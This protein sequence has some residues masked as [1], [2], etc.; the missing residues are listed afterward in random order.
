MKI[1]LVS[2]YDFSSPGGV[3]THINA[4]SKE[5]RA[6]GHDLRVIAPCS[7]DGDSPPYLIKASG[8]VL[9]VPYGGAIA[10]ISLSPR[11]YRR[12]ARILRQE[13]FDVIHLHEPLSPVLSWIVLRH[14]SLSPESLVVGTFH[15]YQESSKSYAWGKLFFQRFINRLDGRIAV[16]E[17]A[18]D[19][20]ARYFPGEYLI[21]PNGIDTQRFGGSNVCPLEPYMDGKLNVLFV[22]RLE[23]RKGFEF[24]LRAFARVQAVLPE[25]RLLVVGAFSPE[26]AEPYRALSR[27]LKL[28]HV[29]FVGPVSD[30]ELPRY[31]RSAH[32]FCAPSIGFES[33]GLVLLEAMA[34]GVPVIASD[35]RGYRA[36]LGNEQAG[37]LV[38]P[39]NAPALARTITQLLQ[40]PLQR[41]IMVQQGHALAE[42]YKWSQI[43]ERILQYYHRLRVRRQSALDINVD[44]WEVEH[45]H[46]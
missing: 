44:E 35:I 39:E 41:E 27:E 5:F 19:Y 31:Y 24:L 20:V 22:G 16:S 18:R 42:K 46:G 36:V 28:K 43:A 40:N 2:P 21:I 23:R 12:V 38:P 8:S 17:A 37:A 25:T 26:D 13:Q 10:R 30:Q 45:A 3:L 34:A 7:A 15:A 4:L 14:I 32:L 6:R 29:L 11:I 33:F 9:A 1:A